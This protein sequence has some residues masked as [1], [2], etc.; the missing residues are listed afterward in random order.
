MC[1]LSAVAEQPVGGKLAKA[2]VNRIQFE[3]ARRTANKAP[4]ESSTFNL[5]YFRSLTRKQIT[6]QHK[7]DVSKLVE[8]MHETDKRYRL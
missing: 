5:H 4:F 3:E 2:T 8:P 7:F 6:T 1:V